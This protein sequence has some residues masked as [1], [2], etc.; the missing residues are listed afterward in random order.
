MGGGLY[1]R[2]QS[3]IVEA[4]MLYR[5]TPPKPET[6]GKFR[7]LA[8]VCALSIVGIVITLGAIWLGLQIGDVLPF[9][10]P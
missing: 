8:L 6:P 1:Y 2:F 7:E 10:P 5:P 3:A 9:P 4:E